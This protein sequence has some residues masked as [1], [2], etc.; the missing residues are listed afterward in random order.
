MPHKK[1]LIA[2]RKR[3]SSKLGLRAFLSPAR[4]GSYLAWDLLRPVLRVRIQGPG[5]S[6]LHA[7]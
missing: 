2:A 3:S 7:K 6:K 1:R 4:V 5:G